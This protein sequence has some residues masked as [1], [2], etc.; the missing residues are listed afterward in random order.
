MIAL[1]SFHRADASAMVTQVV[2]CQASQAQE[3]F[4]SPEPLMR[5]WHG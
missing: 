2:L 1:K 5:I 3:S 4:S